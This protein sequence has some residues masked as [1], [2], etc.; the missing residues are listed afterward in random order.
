MKC[1]KIL[2]DKLTAKDEREA[3]DKHKIP[4]LIPKGNIREGIVYDDAEAEEIY[5]VNIE[6]YVGINI[7]DVFL[8]P[9]ILFKFVPHFVTYSG[10]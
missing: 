4:C 1:K 2:T 8:R 9:K 7:I 5:T 10:V 3:V 6:A